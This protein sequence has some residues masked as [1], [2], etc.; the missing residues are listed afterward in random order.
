MV[1]GQGWASHVNDG[2]HFHKLVPIEV[3][4]LLSVLGAPH[5]PGSLP[6]RDAAALAEESTGEGEPNL[7]VELD[8]EEGHSRQP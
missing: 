4:S 3:A 5:P 1:E 6:D 7:S 2:R 8:G